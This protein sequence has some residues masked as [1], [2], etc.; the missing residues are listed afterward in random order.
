VEYAVEGSKG[1][2]PLLAGPS[3]GA[4][5]EGR[6]DAQRRLLISDAQAFPWNYPTEI[7]A[8]RGGGTGP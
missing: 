5:S 8:D 4:E 6:P 3:I 2:T 7:L 1:A